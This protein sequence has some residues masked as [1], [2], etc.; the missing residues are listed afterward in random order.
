[1]LQGYEASA[2]FGAVPFMG[3]GGAFPAVSEAKDA[4]NDEDAGEE[5]CDDE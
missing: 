3:M 1:M 5:D 2:C 4:E